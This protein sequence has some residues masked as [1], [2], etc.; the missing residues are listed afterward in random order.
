MTKVHTTH[1]PA[2][3]Q[4]VLSLESFNE[5][6][7]WFRAALTLSTKKN[8]ESIENYARELVKLWIDQDNGATIEI[9]AR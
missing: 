8:D 9:V 4:I 2:L 3:A 5:V 7:A 1:A 6:L